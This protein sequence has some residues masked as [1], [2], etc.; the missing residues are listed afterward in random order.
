MAQ[1]SLVNQNN[2][3]NHHQFIIKEQKERY[4]RKTT[5]HATIYP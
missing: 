1:Q 5:N 2:V 3:L 4:D